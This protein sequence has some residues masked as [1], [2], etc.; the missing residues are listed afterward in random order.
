MDTGVTEVVFRKMLAGRPGPF[1]KDVYD[2]LDELGK[3][4]PRQV[5][6]HLACGSGCFQCCL[7]LASCHNAEWALIE[8]YL[9]EKAPKLPRRERRELRRQL[10]KA[11]R[12]Y[13]ALYPKG[14]NLP[15]PGQLLIDWL[16]KPCPFLLEKRCSIYS[17][18]PLLCRIVT[19]KVKCAKPVGGGSRQLRFDYENVAVILVQRHAVRDRVATTTPLHGH[20][21][22]F[23]ETHP[24]F[25]IG[26]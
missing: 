8:E 22:G 7:Q 6:V 1:V 19:S 21:E 16:G 14:T 18:R 9:L 2:V 4:V 10:E 13:A 11:V 26:G 20:I 12:E 3:R 23:L 17:V 25:L 24:D 15:P 5:G